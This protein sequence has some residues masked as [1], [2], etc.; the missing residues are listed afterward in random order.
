MHDTCLQTLE[1]ISTRLGVIMPCARSQC[2]GAGLLGHV[3][4]GI[5]AHLWIEISLSN[6]CRF[7]ALWVINVSETTLP[8]Q[9]FPAFMSLSSYTAANPPRPR[10]FPRKYLAGATFGFAVYSSTTTLAFAGSRDFEGGRFAPG[11]L[12]ITNGCAVLGLPPCVDCDGR[13]C[14]A[15]VARTICTTCRASFS[16]HTN[17]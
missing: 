4:R 10:S 9:S 6:W 3:R 8:A 16:P 2:C 7:V 11:P 1:R 12:N 17:R 13:K 14:P 15:D 5:A